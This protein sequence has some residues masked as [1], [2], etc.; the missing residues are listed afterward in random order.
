M[1]VFLIS[2]W[3]ATS[4]GHQTNAIYTDLL[5]G[6]Q[7]VNHRL[8]VHK[9][10]NSYQLTDTAI[11]WL[12]SYLSKRRQ[13]VILNGKSPKSGKK[14]A[15]A[16]RKVLSLPPGVSFFINDFPGEIEPGFLLYADDANL[17]CQ[18]KHPPGAEWLQGDLN[19]L[20]ECSVRWGWKRNPFKFKNITLILRRTLVHTAYRIGNAIFGL[21]QEVRGL[22]V[23]IDLNLNLSYVHLL[24][25]RP[26]KH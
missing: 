19:H 11:K 23:I 21:V 26:T 4:N 2:A 22:G 15:W 17:F 1:S 10:R 9:L 20:E 12:A 16:S 13:R 25:A 3:E 7:G 5:A 8:L 14:T 24:F 18:I 6:F